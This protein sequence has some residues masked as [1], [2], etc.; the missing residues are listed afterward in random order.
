MKIHV[1]YWE[2]TKRPSAKIQN[3]CCTATESSNRIYTELKKDPGFSHQFWVN[4]VGVT[5]PSGV[6]YTIKI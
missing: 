3:V 1:I 6:K 4:E 2:V 5:I